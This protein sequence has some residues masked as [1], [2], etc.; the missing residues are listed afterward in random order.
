MPALI[1]YILYLLSYPGKYIILI[2]KD[3]KYLY[4]QGAFGGVFVK[5]EQFFYALEIADTGSFSQAARNLYVS[6]PNLSHAV[7]QI[8]KEV[9]FPLFIR[10]ASGVVPT[11]E[12]NA[13]LDHF[14]IIRRE[15]E[16]VAQFLHTPDYPVRLSLRVATLNSNWTTPAFADIIKRYAGIPINFS[17]RNYSYLDDLLPLV[18]SCQVDFAVIGTVSSYLKNIQRK[19]NDHFIDY[20]PICNA[21]ICVAAGPQNPLYSRQDAISVRELYPYTIVEYGNAAEDPSH[22]LPHVIG[23]GNRASGEVKVNYSSLFYST[24][25]NTT[26]VGLIADMLEAFRSRNAWPDIRLLQLKDCEVSAQ[27]GYIKSRR[28]PLTDI[29]AELLDSFKQLF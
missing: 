12:G 21:P 26:A 19:L 2:Y 15:Y 3:K 29:A 22:C 25:Q 17:F 23:L 28:L 18:E 16:Q 8:E 14:R 10:S 20:Y 6:Q 13:V 4:R 27:Y 9:G 11:P 5:I 1:V 24:I 7:K